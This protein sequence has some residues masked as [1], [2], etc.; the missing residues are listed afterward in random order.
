MKSFSDRIL[1]ALITL[2]HERLGLSPNQ[3]T[4]GSLAAGL[5]AAGLLLTGHLAA[6]M[7]ALALSQIL[8]GLD[9]GVARKYGLG[10]ERGRILETA[11]D[12]ACEIAF[13]L[14]LAGAGLAAWTTASLACVAVLLVTLGESVS[15][16]DPGFKRFVLYFGWAL[17]AWTGLPGFEIALTVVFL[18]NLAGFAAGT[19]I[20]DYRFQR[21]IDREAIARREFELAAGIAR[22]PDDPPTFLSRLFS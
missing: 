1:D 16:F 3:L 22:R 11:A 18:A 20:A 7:A 13:F 6:A 12:R 9:G 14:A 19:I 8:D 15:G 5:A 4:A 21:E 17:H 2:A 10:T